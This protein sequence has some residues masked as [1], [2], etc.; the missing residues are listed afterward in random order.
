MKKFL[1]ILW[2]TVKV[3]FIVFFIFTGSLFFREQTIPKSWVDGFSTHVSTTNIIVQCDTAAFGFREGLRVSGIRA[4]DRTQK[5]FLTPVVSIRAV[6]INPFSR[7]VR[8]VEPQYQRL[9]DGY[10]AASGFTE[11]TEKLDFTFPK[12][13]NFRLTVIR[14]NILGLT[15]KRVTAQVKITPRRIAFERVHIDWPDDTHHLELDGLFRFDLTEQWAHG[16][17][18]GESTQSRIRPLLEALDLPCAL[19]YMDAFTEVPKPVPASGTFDVNLVN[20][21]FRMH[22]DLKPTLGRYNGVRMARAEGTLDLYT[23]IRGSN[24]NVKLDV[25]LPMSCDPEGRRLTGALSMQMTNNLVRLAYDVTSE[26]AFTDALKIA[27]FIEPETLDLIVCETKPVITVKGQ[28][29]VSAADAGHN[30][31]AFTAKLARGSFMNLQV[32]D[33]ET[34][35]TIVGE[36]LAFPRFTARGKTGGRY[37][38]SAWLDMPGYDEEKMS[39]GTRVTCAGGSLDEL[40]DFVEMELGEFSG[41]VDGWLELTGPA[42]TNCVSDLNG[43]GSI[44]ISDGHLGQM[45]LFAGLTEIL[46]KKVP[47]VGFLVN[48]SSATADFTITNGVFKSDNI[49]IEGGFFSIKGWGSYDIAKDQLNFTARVQFTRKDSAISKVVHPITWPFTKLLLEFR[50]KG[51]TENP[52]WEYISILDRIL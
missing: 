41:K 52:E 16:E 4:Y 7:K 17:V 12:V 2:K 20:N 42:K 31:L 27:D 21:D 5:D 47:G 32:R 51:S 34:D 45:K 40:A 1:N 36:R 37:A 23:Y 48:Q 14:P 28:S 22:L 44:R 25:A 30:N 46:A 39:F 13:P 38:G 3:L 24:C 43:K 49:F 18:R 50:A 19:P 9:H 15:P 35:F 10:Y 29:G 8:V 6:T 26:L 11:K 33:L